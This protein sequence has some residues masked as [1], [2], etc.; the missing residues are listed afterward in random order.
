MGNKI[1]HKSGMRGRYK[2]VVGKTAPEGVE[3]VSYE[4][5]W[6][7]NLITDLGLDLIATNESYMQVCAVGTGNAVPN[8]SDVQLDSFL[9]STTSVTGRQQGVNSTEP[10]AVWVRKTFRFNQGQAAG[11][12]SEVGIGS[13]ASQLFSRALVL[14]GGGN[15]TSITV[16]PDEWLDVVYEL[17]LEIDTTDVTGQ[18]TLGGNIGGTY[19][20]IFRPCLV[21]TL[22]STTNTT[23]SRGWGFLSSSATQDNTMSNR[24]TN[25]GSDSDGGSFTSD[26]GPVTGQPSGNPIGGVGTGNRPSTLVLPYVPGSHEIVVRR[27]ASLSQNNG[28]IRSMG[29]SVGIMHH[30]IQFDPPIPKTSSDVLVL[31]I[32]HRWGRA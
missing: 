17:T 13:S 15:P 32:A 31:D 30:Q 18:V 7:N 28:N 11:N 26:I 29:F 8:V 20:F 14:D 25:W 10:Y 23:S 24:L 21:T 2:F 6:V 27:T 12:I 16:L 4:S 9:V 19:D 5:D 1:E 22:K 3:S